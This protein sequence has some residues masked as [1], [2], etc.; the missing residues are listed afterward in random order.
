MDFTSVKARLA[1][2]LYTGDSIPFIFKV[3]AYLE[4]GTSQLSD[5][6]LVRMILST[7][8]SKMRKSRPQLAV[9]CSDIYFEIAAAYNIN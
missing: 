5:E 4:S 7:L 9:L 8:E 1:P 2:Y 3:I 6:R